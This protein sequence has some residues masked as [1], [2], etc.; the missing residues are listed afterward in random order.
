MRTTG[1][2]SASSPKTSFPACPGTSEVRKQEA[3][4]E[5]Q[6]FI[7]TCQTREMGYGR[8]FKFCSRL[9]MDGICEFS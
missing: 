4:I 7:F 3:D 6:G 2:W 5:L 9:I 8:I 1:I